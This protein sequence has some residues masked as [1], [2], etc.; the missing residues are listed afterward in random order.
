M[1][2]KKVFNKIK[3]PFNCDYVYTD[4]VYIKTKHTT[5]LKKYI[6]VYWFWSIKNFII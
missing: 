2:I 5:K 3:N 4:S 1:L 6:K